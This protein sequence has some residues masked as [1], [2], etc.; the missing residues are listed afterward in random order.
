M[1]KRWKSFF[2]IKISAAGLLSATATICLVATVTS[3]LGKYWWP[4]ELTTHFPVQYCLTLTTAALIF[5]FLKKFSMAAVCL[6]FSVINLA[7]ILPLYAG[8]NA[9]PQEGVRVRAVFMNVHSG[10]KDYREAI[11]FIQ[12]GNPDLFVAE[13]VTEDWLTNLRGSLTQYP[14]S[15][16]RPRE[17]EF[18]IALFSKKPLED[19]SI[20]QLGTLGLPSLKASMRIGGE[21]LTIIALHPPPPIMEGFRE[22]RL[23]QLK[24]LS[25]VMP[26][27][28]NIIVL[29][30]FNMTPWSPHFQDLL[31]A[32][33]LFDCR[34]GFGIH[35]TWPTTLPW[36]LV[37][38]DHC[39]VS[40]GLATTVFFTGSNI[41]SDHFPLV[42]DLKFVTDSPAEGGS[43]SGN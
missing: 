29:G 42:V 39:L 1:N 32:A 20:I 41:G 13:E 37:P 33:S 16:A 2:S 11:E 43:R 23:R 21:R 38:I 6:V 36:M 7:A 3:F 5:I 17:D 18:G 28:R 10:N 19:A 30:D 35:P 34:K 31:T 12:S 24:N 40:K 25:K 8:R 22:E 9:S 15:I 27:E 4:F 26:K 14:H